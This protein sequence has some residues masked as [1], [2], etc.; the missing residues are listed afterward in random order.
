MRQTK[1]KIKE[2]EIPNEETLEVFRKTDNVDDLIVCK[3][4]KDFFNKLKI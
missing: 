1:D 3:D 2:I 4:V